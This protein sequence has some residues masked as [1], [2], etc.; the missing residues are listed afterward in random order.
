M[1]ESHIIR[2]RCDLCERGFE[3][4]LIHSGGDSPYGGFDLRDVMKDWGLHNR[5][6]LFG[7]PTHICTDCLESFEQWV[8]WRKRQVE[9]PK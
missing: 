9:A 1:I 6:D 4:E 5:E 3:S 2:G 8:R 7:T